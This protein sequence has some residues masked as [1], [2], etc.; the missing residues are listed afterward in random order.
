MSRD[1]GECWRWARKERV[2]TVV[3]HPASSAEKLRECLSELQNVDRSGAGQLWSCWSTTVTDSKRSGG[4]A[5]RPPLLPAS[6]ASPKT[7]PLGSLP[8]CLSQA[9]SRSRLCPLRRGF[10]SHTRCAR[11]HLPDSGAGCRVRKAFEYGCCA[12]E[13]NSGGITSER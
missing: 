9:T 8:C 7:P 12:T 1:T 6:K 5:L 13:E 4:P 11:W 10:G 2:T 3:L